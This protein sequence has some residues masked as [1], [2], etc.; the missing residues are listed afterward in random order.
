MFCLI[1]I[2]SNVIL[3]VWVQRWQVHVRYVLSRLVW[4]RLQCFASLI[5]LQK[6]WVNKKKK[7]ERTRWNISCSCFYFIYLRII[8][9]VIIFGFVI[10]FHRPFV[11]CY[12]WGVL[13]FNSKK[14]E[15]NWSNRRKKQTKGPKRDPSF[16]PLSI[17]LTSNAHHVCW[18]ANSHS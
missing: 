4:Q 12:Y 2:V 1:F 11:W 7:R 9:V 16:V 14:R 3:N 18:V 15:L 13:D 10:F 17:F 6:R 5:N 8:I